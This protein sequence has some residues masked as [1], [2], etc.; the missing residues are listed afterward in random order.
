MSRRLGSARQ[1]ESPPRL[2]VEAEPVLDNVV[3]L[4]GSVET[5]CIDMSTTLVK[6]LT[7][8][9]GNRH[10]AEELTQEALAQAV[11]NWDSVSTMANP[12]GWVYRTALNLS[13]SL[14]RRR[15]AERRAV[16]RLAIRPDPMVSLE[17]TD[18]AEFRALIQHLSRRQREVV[19]LRFAADLSVEVTAEVM[20]VTSGTVK[21]L[22]HRALAQLREGL[23]QDIDPGVIAND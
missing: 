6:M 8:R 16:K 13:A 19:A 10:L 17:V 20:G 5:F 14:F 3:D 18:K 4:P 21:T 22:T 9:V 11:V 1:S 2:R 23:G 7:V 15:Q 12:Q